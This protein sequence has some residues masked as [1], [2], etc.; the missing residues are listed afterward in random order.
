M[1]YDRKMCIKRI[2]QTNYIESRNN[3]FHKI[4]QFQLK[5]KSK[6]IDDLEINIL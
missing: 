2:K 5:I 3:Q 4:I 1:K 6:I